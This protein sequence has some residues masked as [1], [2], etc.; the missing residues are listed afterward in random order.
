MRLGRSRRRFPVTLNQRDAMPGCENPP[1]VDTDLF[2]LAAES[3]D[4]RRGV[5]LFYCMLEAGPNSPL[6][7]AR[8]MTTAEIG[9]HIVGGG[10]VVCTMLQ[11]HKAHVLPHRDREHLSQVDFT[12]PA[13]NIVRIPSQRKADAVFWT[14]SAVDKFFLPYYARLYDKTAY[15]IL[16]KLFYVASTPAVWGMTHLPTSEYDTIKGLSALGVPVTNIPD[17]TLAVLREIYSVGLILEGAP[18]VVNA[19]EHLLAH[20]RA[21]LPAF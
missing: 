12:T 18:G 20:H 10:K 11:L 19:F 17:A 2:R 14:E 3:A 7:G 15:D 6:E 1:V 8:V 9:D 5:D 21:W 13:G 4:G 16:W